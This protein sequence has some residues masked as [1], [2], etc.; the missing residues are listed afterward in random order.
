MWDK[1]TLDIFPES[2]QQK[3]QFIAFSIVGIL[4]IYLYGFIPFCFGFLSLLFHETGHYI[5][6]IFYGNKVNNIKLSLY[7]KSYVHSFGNRSNIE[8]I[9]IAS[10]GPFIGI[11]T[12]F[13]IPAIEPVGLEVDIW[14]TARLVIIMQLINLIP[15]KN[16]DGSEIIKSISS[17]S[18]YKI[19]T[20][21]YVSIF[22]ILFFV[23][24]L[25]IYGLLYIGYYQ[26]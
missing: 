26:L 12:I 11:L 19:L 17:Y 1:I 6:N 16:S 8:N 22:Y 10:S 2:R 7:D 18:R 21:F 13:I 4:F 20:V 14:L 23:Y 25:L 5:L 3:K 15:I 24:S 9:L